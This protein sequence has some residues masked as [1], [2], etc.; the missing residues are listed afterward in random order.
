MDSELPGHPTT[1]GAT[2]SSN[3]GPSLHNHLM[4][5]DVSTGGPSLPDLSPEPEANTVTMASVTSLRVD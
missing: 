4:A 2:E 5:G 3:D 1:P